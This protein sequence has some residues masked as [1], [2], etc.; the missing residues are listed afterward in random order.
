MKEFSAITPWVTEKMNRLTDL[1]AQQEYI[2]G[3]LQEV[4]EHGCLP[5]GV[6]AFLTP[7]QMRE[8]RKPSEF[9]SR[10]PEARHFL[11]FMR[12]KDVQAH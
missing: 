2:T 6:Q 9:V 3:L 4:D 12:R 8:F 10:V 11:D 5:C 1:K 7:L